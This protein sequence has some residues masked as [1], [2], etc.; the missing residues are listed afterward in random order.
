MP[1]PT[2]RACG[3]SA[4]P[5]PAEPVRSPRRQ[6]VTLFPENP[7]NSNSRRILLGSM[8]SVCRNRGRWACGG[9]GAVPPTPQTPESRGNPGGAPISRMPTRRPEV[10]QKANFPG[11]RST[12]VTTRNKLCLNPNLTAPTGS[13]WA[14]YIAFLCLSFLIW[15]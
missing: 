12:C 15:E 5:C 3:P 4:P 13:P 10:S 11:W 9:V 14:S 7:T 8:D 1:G 2:H 6:V